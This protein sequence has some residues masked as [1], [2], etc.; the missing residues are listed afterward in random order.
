MRYQMKEKWFAVG[1]D[2]VV[3]DETGNRAFY[4]DGKV[5]RLRKTLEVLDGGGR[6]VATIRKRILSWGPT[7]DVVSTGGETLATVHKAHFTLFRDK[8]TIDVPGPDD[9]VARGNFT[10]HE[11][12]FTRG[13]AEV[14]WVSRRW[15]SL[16]H[17]YGIEVGD[18][19]DA[20][21]VICSAAIIELCIH[22]QDDDDHGKSHAE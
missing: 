1:D 3:Q 20:L 12:V 5:L 19:R 13:G 16:S 21:V 2:F 15:F 4:L 14:A 9:F 18:D 17:V 6:H 8:F 11:Y 10:E 7:F 22:E